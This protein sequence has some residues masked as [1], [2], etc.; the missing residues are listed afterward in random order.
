[1]VTTGQWF[2]AGIMIWL[3]GAG[4]YFPHVWRRLDRAAKRDCICS[5]SFIGMIEVF[6]SYFPGAI[7]ALVAVTALAWPGGW[8]VQIKYRNLPRCEYCGVRLPPEQ[9][10]Q[11]PQN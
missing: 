10:P 1:M 5:R 8:V 4:V 7:I 9:N 11:A 3:C 6:A 2:L